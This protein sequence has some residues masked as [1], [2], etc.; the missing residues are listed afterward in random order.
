MTVMETGV[1]CA[2]GCIIVVFAE[3]DHSVAFLRVL[4][5][6]YVLYAG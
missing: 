6:R 4:R 2:D 3:T 5:R 1:L